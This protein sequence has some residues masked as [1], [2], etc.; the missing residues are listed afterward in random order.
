M[1]L[2]KFNAPMYTIIQPST[3]KEI[4]YRPFLVKEEKILLMAKESG[5]DTD[6]YNAV[7]Q[8]V[9]NC[10][11]EEGFDVDAVPIYDLEYLFIKIRAISVSNIVKF[12][13]EDSDDGILY[14]LEVDLD[15][16]EVQMPENHSNKVMINDDVGIIMKPPTPQ[17]SETLNGI[18]SVTD[19]VYETVKSCIDY[20]FDAEDTYL[21]SAEPEAEREVFLESLP[22]SVYK[23]IGAYF[24]NSPKIEHVVTYENSSGTTKNVIFR[25][26]NDFFTLG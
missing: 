10:V 18:T 3:Q 26:I 20:I 25:N 2:P 7:K 22:L 13:V 19:V 1:A 16:V 15:D 12:Q 4:R 21:W 6:Q 24:Q 8:I 23:D 9:N 14:D 5:Q 17:L 11:M